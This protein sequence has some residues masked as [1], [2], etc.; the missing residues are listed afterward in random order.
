MKSV[1]KKVI[2][3]VQMAVG[4][5]IIE[6]VTDTDEIQLVKISGLDGEVQDGVERIQNYGFTSNVP[7]GGE[8][9]VLYVQGN[10]EDGIVITADHGEYR[11]S[12]LKSGETAVY[13][14]HGQ[15]MKQLENGDTVFNDG[16]DFAVAFNDLKAGFDQLVT[17]VNAIVL[18]V[19]GAVPLVPGTPPTAGPPLVP[20]TASIDAAQITEIKVP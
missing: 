17:Y 4:R 10:R 12:G 6:A 15:T 7:K 13:S 20:S 8:S 5:A 3:R 9:V 18:P 2:H 11:V 14:M 16:T 19:V 1:L